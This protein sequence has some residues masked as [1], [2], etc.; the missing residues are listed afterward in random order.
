MRVAPWLAALLLLGTVGADPSQSA[1][2][3]ARSD[4][5]SLE[6]LG[7]YVSRPCALEQVG[8]LSILCTGSSC[9]F[10]PEVR[11][12]ARGGF[13]MHSI[14]AELGVRVDGVDRSVSSACPGPCTVTTFLDV[15]VAPGAC[16]FAYFTSVYRAPQFYGTHVLQGFEFCR[17]L[18]GVGRFS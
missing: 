10:A 2:V 3:Y 9:R 11:V 8:T 13:V 16:G 7:G 15:P 4:S 12:D 6:P 14:R 1:D 18:D 5:C 17:G